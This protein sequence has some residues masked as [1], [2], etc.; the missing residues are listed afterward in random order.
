MDFWEAFM[1][2]E[3]A[4]RVDSQ[5]EHGVCMEALREHTSREYEHVWNSSF[6]DLYW[7]SNHVGGWTGTSGPYAKQKITFAQWC[8][9]IT[10]STE[11]TLQPDLS[12]V[13]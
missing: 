4:V 6:P 12:E 10:A 13:I 1:Q 8:E 3:Y 9:M 5:A 2:K 7:A 11:D